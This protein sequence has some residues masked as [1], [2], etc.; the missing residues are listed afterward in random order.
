MK[1]NSSLK[2]NSGKSYEEIIKLMINSTNIIKTLPS[3][4]QSGKFSVSVKSEAKQLIIKKNTHHKFNFV[5]IFYQCVFSKDSFKPSNIEI[6]Y[7]GEN[8]HDYIISQIPTREQSVSLKSLGM[9]YFPEM[10]S[11]VIK[12]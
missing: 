3:L 7:T 6:Y 9:K 12:F 10:K 11:L 8:S 5:I 1:K 2:K 4:I